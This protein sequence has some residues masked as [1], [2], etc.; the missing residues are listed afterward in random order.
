[1]DAFLSSLLEFVTSP[2]WLITANFILAALLGLWMLRHR[3]L[4][5]RARE[6]QKNSRDLIENLSEGIYRSSPDG[7][8]LSA[9]R[10]LVKL[11]GYS[12]EQ[13]MLADVKDIGK[14]WYVEPTR[15]EEFRAILRRDGHVED[16]ISEVYR[17]KTRERIWISELARLVC[18]PR[19][20]S[21]CSTRAPSARSPKR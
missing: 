12:S 11:N 18:T 1:M 7:R 2:Q 17:Y 10:A 6:E 9:N 21:R 5:Y 3:A 16:F 8:Q 20:A 14:K 13:E 4:Y 19:A 15:R